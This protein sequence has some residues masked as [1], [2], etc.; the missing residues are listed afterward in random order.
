MFVD[1]D[2]WHDGAIGVD[3]EIRS[4]YHLFKKMGKI[5]AEDNPIKYRRLTDVALLHY[6]PYYWASYLGVS[7]LKHDNA[8]LHNYF[9]NDFFWYMQKLDVDFDIT[10]VD[11]VGNYKLVFALLGDFMDATDAQKLLAYVKDGGTLVILPYVPSIDLNG[12]GMNEFRQVT[13]IKAEVQAED[14]SQIHTTYGTVEYGGNLTIYQA[15]G[16]VLAGCESGACGYITPLGKGNLITLGFWLD[17]TGDSV[18]NGILRQSGVRNY[19]STDDTG[20]EAELHLSTETQILLYVVNREHTTKDV[21]VFLDLDYLGINPDD[22][23]EIIDVVA[24][25]KIPQNEGE[26]LWTGKDLHN[27]IKLHFDGQDAVMMKIVK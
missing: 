1:R 11:S 14:V 6:R 9:R 20:S 7:E 25:Q 2:I 16:D 4:K 3:G 26:Y 24:E 19:A 17:K 22:E 10:E 27:G 12:L 5:M 8:A 13:S 18:L 15:A 21:K 23:M